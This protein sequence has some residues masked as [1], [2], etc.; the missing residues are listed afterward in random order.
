MQSDGHEVGALEIERA[1]M[2]EA[3]VMMVLRDDNDKG[4]KIVSQMT[5][6]GDSG[7]SSSISQIWH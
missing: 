5:L 3:K 4:I 2:V 1:L 7:P 6:H